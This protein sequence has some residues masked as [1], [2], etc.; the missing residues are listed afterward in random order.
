MRN[1]EYVKRQLLTNICVDPI[2]LVSEVSSSSLTKPKYEVKAA[3]VSE[4]S[5]CLRLVFPGQL[6]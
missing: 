4:T 6:G 2:L 1:E 3:T 5:L